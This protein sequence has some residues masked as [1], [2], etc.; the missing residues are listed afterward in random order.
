L[1][2]L[3][4]TIGS[5]FGDERNFDRATDRSWLWMSLL[6]SVLVLFAF[7]LSPP[8]VEGDSAFHSARAVYAG[9]LTGMEPRHPLATIPLRAI[10][11][12]LL[13]VGLGQFSLKAF[14]VVSSLGMAG[15]FLLLA[16]SIYPRFIKSRTVC[17]FSALGTFMCYGILSRASVVEVYGP[18]LFF[19]V[20]LIA[21]CLHA[22]FD[23][24]RHA[25]IAG[26]LLVLAVGFHVANVLIIPAVIAMVTGRIP[27]QQILRVH[28]WTGG[29][30][31]VGT[32]ALL[33]LLWL[34][35]G[36]MKWPPDPATIF[37]QRDPE[38]PLG[39]SGHLSRGA[40]GFARA[41]A[42]LPYHR[43][44]RASFAA[45]YAVGACGAI[46]LFLHLARGGLLQ[47][48]AKN[49][50]LFLTLSLLAT[51]FICMG[52][53]YYPSDPERWLFLIPALWLL[54]GMAW[55]QYIPPLGRQTIAWE[56]PIVLAA[57]VFGLGA[58][59]AAALLP[60]AL[61][62]RQLDSL[63]YLS[64]VTT[65]DDLV[66][67]PAGIGSRLLDFYL[68]RPIQGRD[69]SAWALSREHGADLKGIQADLAGQI[70]RTLQTGR[71]VFVFGFIGERLEKQR[72]HPWAHLLHDC[73]PETFRS[74]LDQ[75]QYDLIYPSSRE[76]ISTVRLKPRVGS[77][78]HPPEVAL[79]QAAK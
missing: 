59:N 75:Y 48:R 44:L 57:I 6:T 49:N 53:Y 72:G 55:D 40:Y 33:F 2:T 46:I 34:G 36:G 61:R 78:S 41:V 38:P 4:A 42:F 76:H 9:F 39:L 3:S 19:D 52:L 51:P 69:L 54:I 79:E 67:S 68:D 27:R 5:G 70:D 15:T 64:R 35:P 1:G 14:V 24:T 26:L 31:L 77:P 28:C 25:V 16:R 71:Q 23:R 43:D 37:P 63:R 74:V 66:I 50:K 29:T 11:V 13:A 17:L 20:A 47:E 21:Y 22:S 12:T 73:G 62:S 45:A 18:A 58:Y 32:G 60:G 56:S 65:P 7:L 30:F 10:Y 8:V